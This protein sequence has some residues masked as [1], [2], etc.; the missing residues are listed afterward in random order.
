MVGE[1]FLG[2]KSHVK[3]YLGIDKQNSLRWTDLGQSLLAHSDIS[4]ANLTRISLVRE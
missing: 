1:W 4:Q 2:I 3:Y